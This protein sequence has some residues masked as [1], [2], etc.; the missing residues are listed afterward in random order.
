VVRDLGEGDCAVS[1]DLRQI[2]LEIAQTARWYVKWRKLQKEAAE[3]AGTMSDL[4]ARRH[5]L[6]I[7]EAYRLLAGRAMERSVQLARL[8][9][10]MKKP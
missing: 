10:H 7:A 8:A 3:I 4:E 5:M 2:E 6:F 9:S 1:R